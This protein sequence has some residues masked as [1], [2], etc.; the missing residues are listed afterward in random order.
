MSIKREEIDWSKIPVDTKIWVK[1]F[2]NNNWIPR[3]FAKYE[4]GKVF[5]Y[6][7]GRTSWSCGDSSPLGWDYAKL[8]EEPKEE[9]PHITWDYIY[10]E[11]IKYC[12]NIGCGECKYC[13]DRQKPTEICR[14]HWIKDN[15]DKIIKEYYS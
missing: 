4:N 13:T 12:L 6:D 11:N 9:K 3:Y 2:E 1:D 14:Q 5:T 8:V 15:F 7:Y 10:K